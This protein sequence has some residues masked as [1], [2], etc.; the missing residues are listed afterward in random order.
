MPSEEVREGSEFTLPIQGS[1]VAPSGKYFTGWN[2][3]AKDYIPGDNYTMSTTNLT[4]TAQWAT[5]ES[6]NHYHYSYK[7]ATRYN[8]TFKNPLGTAAASGDNQT[9]TDGNL[10]SSLGGI[11]NVAISGAKYDGKGSYMDAYIKI[12]SGGTAKV[13]VTIADGYAATLK[14]KAGGYSS[15]P[16]IAVSNSA[17]K[18]SGTVGGKATTEDNYNTLVYTL[19]S[20]TNEIT[21]TSQNMYISEI[22]V[23]TTQTVSGTISASGWNTFS[24]NY[25]L[26]LST[27]TGGTAYYAS[28][29]DGTEHKVTLT[30]T[31][32]KVNAGE[33]LMIKGTAG[34]TFTIGVTSAA[35][36]FEETNLLV[37]LPTGGTVTKND[38]NYV[39]G[40]ADPA[41]P[42]FYYISNTSTEPTLGAGKAYLHTESPL[43][44][45]LNI[46]FEDGDVTAVKSI[47][48]KE[49]NSNLFYNL[50][51][52]RVNANHKGIVIV[53][54]KKFMN[55]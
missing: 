35:A 32:A 15:N 53:N 26:D 38:N 14:I 40:W 33:G 47:K 31:D 13:V 36:T 42:G 49:E 22:D 8:G 2:D 25:K 55:K 11:T 51:G 1:I 23:V 50:N 6:A 39:F 7:D 44:N 20:G 27:I 46:D 18:V 48:T 12:A 10:C 28:A 34:E 4:F 41:S 3:G 29:V 21:C 17:V 52:Q 9:L 45:Q 54:G 24:T 19:Y 30:S 16:T 43:A 37:G 5:S